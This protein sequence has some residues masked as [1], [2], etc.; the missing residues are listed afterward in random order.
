MISQLAVA[1]LIMADFPVGIRTPAPG[2]Q[3]FMAL[4]LPPCATRGE[5]FN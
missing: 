3:R 4:P 2:P 5:H 1:S